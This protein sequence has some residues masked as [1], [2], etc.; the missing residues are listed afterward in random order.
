MRAIA[1]AIALC[2]ASVSQAQT[3]VEE[4]TATVVPSGPQ[5]SAWASWANDVWLSVNTSH[6]KRVKCSRDTQDVDEVSTNGARCS[7]I[8]TKPQLTAAQF[9]TVEQPGEPFLAARPD[10]AGI[11]VGGASVDNVVIRWGPTFVYGADFT[12]LATNASNTLSIPGAQLFR[13]D[14][15]YDATGDPAEPS[16]FDVPGWRARGAKRVEVTAAERLECLRT[17]TCGRQVD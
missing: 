10:P 13:V 1:I 11:P 9:R 16:P 8:E 3:Y 7:V 2:A 17:Q 6:V 5:L 14:V 4:F 15:W 12:T